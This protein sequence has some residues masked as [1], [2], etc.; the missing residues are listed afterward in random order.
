MS[1]TT[2]SITFYCRESKKSKTGLAPVELGICLN[3]ERKFINLPLKF[4]P[5]DYNKKRQPK[6][7]AE[8]IEA[9]RARVNQYMV[10][11]VN[12]G[13][14]VTADGLR[15]IIQTGGIQT[16]TVNDLFKE[17][18][19]ILNMRVGTD[20]SKGVYRKYE[21]VA[22][23]FLGYIDGTKEAVT[24][25]NSQIRS[26][27]A[28]LNNQYDG[29]TSASMMTKLKAFIVFGLD[30]NRIKINP[31]QGIKIVKPKKDITY[32]AESEIKALLGANMGNK[33]LDRVKDMF[34]IMCGTGLAYADLKNLKKEDIKN[35]NG[36]Y[37]ICKKR[38]KNGQDYTSVVLPFAK[39]ILDRYDELPVISNQKMNTY[40]KRIGELLGMDKE[41][42]CHLAR[43]SYATFLLNKGVRMETVS[44][45]LGHSNTKITQQ[46]YA[47]FINKNIIEEVAAIDFK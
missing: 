40:L 20:L 43:K 3:G 37:Y 41:L 45:T 46:Y 1:R 39:D 30:N 13:I 6:E 23:K 22:E 36:T 29:S 38:V 35:L 2:S 4:K 16:Y 33:S 47:S 27:Y 14:P 10:D 11:M 25:C 21:L 31:F 28:S 9:F 17:Y 5:E 44:K 12:N 8:A 7:I 42:H 18:L 34:L 19:E 32:L 24:I 15:S 26:F